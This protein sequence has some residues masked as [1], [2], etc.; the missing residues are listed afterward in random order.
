DSLFHPALS[1]SLRTIGR[2]TA[3][4]GWRHQPRLPVCQIP[5]PVRRLA[6]VGFGG[7][8]PGGTLG[9]G[10]A[11]LE[12]GAFGG[13]GHQATSLAVS[14]SVDR[15][16]MR[17]RRSQSSAVARLQVVAMSSDPMRRTARAQ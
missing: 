5:E 8:V 16:M 9:V 11:D 3:P 10:D 1:F 17:S 2:L 6:S 14:R 12:A 15:S 7:S 4:L 13:E